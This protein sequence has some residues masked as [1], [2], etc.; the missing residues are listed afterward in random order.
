[1]P[2]GTE[3]GPA[4]AIR[5]ATVADAAVVAE[6]GARTFADTFGA[7]NRPED[8]AAHLAA[9]FGVPQQTAELSD[10]NY[11][12]LLAHAGGALAGFAQVRR[13]R[14]PPCVQGPAPVEL[15]R[16][17]VDRPW[18]GRGVAAPLLAAVDDVVREFGGRTVWLSVWERNP[19]GRAFYV[20]SGFRQTGTA[21]FWVGPDRQTDHI[22][23]R[24]LE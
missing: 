3:T 17:Y 13:K 8:M 12:T 21:D 15:H 10:P 23:E 22:L 7:D 16:I 6:F 19:R 14:A 1:M 20:K 11:V 9:T 4:I 24:T 2:D 5:R 18:Q